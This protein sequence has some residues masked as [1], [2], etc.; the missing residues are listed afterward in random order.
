[1]IKGP[2]LI[3][4]VIAQQKELLSKYKDI[5]NKDIHPWV[6]PK[7]KTMTDKQFDKFRDIQHTTKQTE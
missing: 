4:N 3:E 1:L 5:K 7:M 6:I 2:D